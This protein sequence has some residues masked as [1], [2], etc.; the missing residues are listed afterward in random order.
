MQKNKDRENHRCGTTGKSHVKTNLYESSRNITDEFSQATLKFTE[1]TGQGRPHAVSLAWFNRHLGHRAPERKDAKQHS[2][3]TIMAKAPGEWWWWRCLA[4]V[5]RLVPGGISAS[6]GSSEG[7]APSGEKQRR[8]D[9]TTQWYKLY[10]VFAGDPFIMSRWVYLFMTR[11]FPSCAL[12]KKP[13]L[14]G[15]GLR[16]QS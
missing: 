16:V 3:S 12:P 10:R 5:D 7:T 1:H 8:K 4:G 2:Y 15:F 6:R 13:C 9:R 11:D 14:L